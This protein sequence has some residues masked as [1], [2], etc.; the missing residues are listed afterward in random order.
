[1]V[2][3]FY[4]ADVRV[5]REAE[6][7][8][9][10]GWAVDVLCLRR[11][12]EKQEEEVNG[13]RVFRLPAKRTRGRK[14]WYLWEYGWFLLLAFFKLS[15]R[16]LRRPYQAVHVHNMP[17]ILV[18]SAMLPRLSGAKVILDLHDPMPEVY[19]AKYSIGRTHPIIYLLSFLEKQSIKFAHLVLTPN[20][21]FRDLFISRGCPEKKIHIVMNSPQEKIFKGPAGLLENTG[22][23]S[24]PFILMYHGA[25]MEW[26]GLETAL[27]ALLQLQ[28]TIPNLRFEVYGDGDA[29]KF[30]LN[31]IKE[32][33]LEKMVHYYGYRPLE[34]IAELIKKI[35]VGII[36]NPLSP[37]T[38]LN[39]PTRIF[40]YLSMAK[41][42]IAPKTKGILD[43]FDEGDLY[44]FEPGNPRSLAGVVLEIYRNPGK[45]QEILRRGTRVYQRHRW[46]LQRRGLIEAFRPLLEKGNE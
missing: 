19:M 20:I 40:E 5:R 8:V 21:A 33:G 4:P 39:F 13:V 27:Q 1:V 3:S 37:F 10:A 24:G 22:G 15:L 28:E 17:D 38:N 2:F 6:A 41:P 7:L 25:I 14:L 32:L 35:D 45:K 11:N 9:E 43:Y 12:R 46:E 23:E 29:V 16:H 36:P 30:F 18:F 44:F 42:V 34:M 31:R 26:Y